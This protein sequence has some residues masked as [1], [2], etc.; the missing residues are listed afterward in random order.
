[1]CDESIYYISSSS[2]SSLIWLIHLT[3]STDDYMKT[4]ACDICSATI[5][6]CI[7]NCILRVLKITHPLIQTSCIT[8]IRE[9]KAVIRP[10]AV[11]YSFSAQ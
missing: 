7:A 5:A 3:V 11:L 10:D 6:V 9:L 2:S 1:M 4:S 8:A